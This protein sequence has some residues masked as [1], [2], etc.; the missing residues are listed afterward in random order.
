[1][2][3][4]KM[5]AV[6]FAKPITLAGDLELNLTLEHIAEF[7]TFVL[8]Q[9]IAAAAGLDMIDVT[10]KKIARSTGDDGF[11]LHAFTAANLIGLYHWPLAATQHDAIG[12]GTMLNK[13][14]TGVLSAEATLWIIFNDGLARPFSILD[15]SDSEQPAALARLRSVNP[16][17]RR[18]CLILGPMR[19]I[20]GTFRSFTR[21][22][23]GLCRSK[24]LAP[25]S[26]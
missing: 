16:L 7:L 13:P 19:G 11:E 22:F 24:G 20:G 26:L 17:S 8:N 1:M 18:V 12:I 14:A 25:I 5:E 9:A 15:R 6:A 3:R 21:P 10:G 23:A 2:L 4:P